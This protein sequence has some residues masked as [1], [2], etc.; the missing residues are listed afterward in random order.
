MQNF[1]VVMNQHSP[2]SDS[3]AH[4]LV[5]LKRPEQRQLDQQRR[6]SP[7]C[8]TLGLGFIKILMLVLVLVNMHAR[9]SCVPSGEASAIGWEVPR[10]V[11]HGQGGEAGLHAEG[12]GQGAQMPCGGGGWEGGSYQGCSSNVMQFKLQAGWLF[13]GLIQTDNIQLGHKL[14]NKTLKAG[15]DVSMH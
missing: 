5:T 12:D 7:R 6:V 2:V 13:P 9:M 11:S 1:S 4:F 3:A 10:G 14:Q 8:N 15:T